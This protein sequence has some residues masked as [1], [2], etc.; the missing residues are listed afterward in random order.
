M[1]RVKLPALNNNKVYLNKM[2]PKRRKP[3]IKVNKRRK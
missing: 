2:I 1:K 3:Q